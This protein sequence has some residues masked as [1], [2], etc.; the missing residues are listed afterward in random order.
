LLSIG[1]YCRPASVDEFVVMPNHIHAIILISTRD[2]AGVPGVGAQHTPQP[3][4]IPPTKDGSLERSPA[5]TPCA[6]PLQPRRIQPA[7]L[8]AVVRAFKSASTKRINAIRNKPRALVWQ[9]NYYEH[10]IRGED[11]L[12]R[13][14]RYIR[15]NPA[16]W[17]N[18]QDNPANIPKL[19]QHRRF[20]RQTHPAA[21]IGLSPAPQA[22]RWRIRA[23][24]R[25]TTF[26]P[27]KL[28]PLAPSVNPFPGSVDRPSVQPPFLPNKLACPQAG[29]VVRRISYVV[30]HN[31][32]RASA[33]AAGASLH[34]LDISQSL[35]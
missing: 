33:T 16:K 7:S 28:P 17:A 19:P 24:F 25:R 4:I 9:R 1:R 10:I 35:V 21:D 23:P 26:L 22:I 11:D 13:I 5:D 30:P 8:G 31:P 29:L 12:N 20:A 15:D 2:R 34:D 6:A 27:N 32:P 3:E 18:D 14:R